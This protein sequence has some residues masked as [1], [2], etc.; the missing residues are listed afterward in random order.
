MKKLI[1]LIALLP[2]IG[3]S[4]NLFKKGTQEEEKAMTV[5]AIV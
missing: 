2:L 5:M 1:L 3:F 4:Q